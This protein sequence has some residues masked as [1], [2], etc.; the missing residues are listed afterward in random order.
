MNEPQK[1]DINQADV[2]T[3]AGLP[4]VGEVRARRI[5]D[6]R[7]T[8]HPFEEVIEL[9]AVPGI[10]ERMVR[11]F[12][13]Q[14]TV[15]A[16]DKADTADAV[17]ANA[18]DTVDVALD[19]A[20]SPALEEAETAAAAPLP[21]EAPAEAAQYMGDAAEEVT[22]PQPV[23]A[24]PAAEGAGVPAADAAAADAADAAVVGEA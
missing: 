8:V 4:G 5:V 14:V 3:L 10:S 21:P 20:A 15:G 17:A 19:E 23:E 7:E 22:L 2:A 18:A 13:D 9:T 11:A 12:A 24:A 16:T 6:Y 1:I